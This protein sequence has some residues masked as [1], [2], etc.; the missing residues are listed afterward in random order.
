MKKIYILAL[1][2]LIL[3]SSCDKFSS[4]PCSKEEVKN[5]LKQQ[6]VLGLSL[7][8]LFT[9]GEVPNI[10]VNIIEIGEPLNLGDGKNKCNATVEIENKKLMIEYVVKEISSGSNKVNNLEITDIHPINQ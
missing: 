5:Q 9:P 6:I 2:F 10:N 1:S 8:N 3:S 7:L 4:N